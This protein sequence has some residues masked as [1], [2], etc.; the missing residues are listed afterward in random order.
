MEK[1]TASL[2]FEELG[3]FDSPAFPKQIFKGSL[4]KY[5][6]EIPS[7]EHGRLIDGCR[8]VTDAEEAFEAGNRGYTQATLQRLLQQYSTLDET[9]DSNEGGEVAIDYALF[10]NKCSRAVELVKD[11]ISAIQGLGFTQE[12]LELL[13][14]ISRLY[15]KGSVE[16]SLLARQVLM[17]MKSLSYA[18]RMQELQSTLSAIAKTESSD[19]KEKAGESDFHYE[20]VKSDQKSQSRMNDLVN[21]LD[22]LFHFVLPI[23]GTDVSLAVK[24][25][26][27]QLYIERSYRA[28]QITDLAF[29][30]DDTNDQVSPSFPLFSILSLLSSSFLLF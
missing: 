16:V 26:A 10:K 30:D 29:Y 6:K 1:M 23:F 21:S 8:Q 11:V 20:T 28:Y 7:G 14:Q 13:S 9:K 27:L 17:D 4:A 19:E 22:S 24:K 12:M 25:V 18:D 2:T 5:L 15:G 3:A